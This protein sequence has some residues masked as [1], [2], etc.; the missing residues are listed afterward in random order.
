MSAHA[1]I[2]VA[3]VQS[4]VVHTRWWIALAIAAVVLVVVVVLL[5]AIR[6]TAMRI[7]RCVSD[8]WTGGTHIAA[9]TVTLAQLER[10]NFLAGMLLE[11]AGG[12]VRN[13]ERIRSA[14]A[15]SASGG[16]P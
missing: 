14:T 12:I 15:P 2:V 8:I 10:T 11:H 13:A 5:E 4:T 16:A 1:V 7:R 9:N 6:R 3:A